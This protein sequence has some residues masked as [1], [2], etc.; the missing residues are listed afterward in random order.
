M[1]I[2]AALESPSV[3]LLIA[4]VFAPAVVG[5]LSLAIP[6][7][8][9]S[10]RTA[11]AVLAPALSLLLLGVSILGGVGSTSVGYEWLPQ[12]HMSLRF[13]PDGL[14]LFFGMLVSMFGVAIALYAR[15]YFGPSREDLYRFYPT[16]LLF[17]TAMLGLV[18]ADSFM[19]ML[20]FWELTS[21]SSFL[22]IGWE[23]DD[24]EA[25]KKALGAFMTTA[26]GGL[27][28][29]AGLI[30]LGVMTGAW[31]FSDL[32][33]LMVFNA[34]QAHPAGVPV[35]LGLMFI[36]IM[37]KSAQWPLH[38]WLPGA[39]SAPTPVSAY[40]HSATMV[41][42][43]IYLLARLAPLFAWSVAW[44]VLVIPIG[45]ITML[46][47]AY[48]ALRKDV[49]KHI[50][51]Y[52]TISQLGLLAVMYG[53]AHWRHEHVVLG[54][55]LGGGAGGGQE[56]MQ[57]NLIWDTVQ[58]LNHALYKAPLF[59]LAGAV[60]H[61]LHVKQ[62]SQVQGLVWKGGSRTIIALLLAAAAY[63][64]AAGPFTLSFAA[65]EMFLY[66]I[67]HA[68]HD[69]GPWYLW[70]LQ[71]AAVATSVLN[72]AIFV[73]IVAVLFSRTRRQR[74]YRQDPD[75][76][77]DTEEL[78][79]HAEPSVLWN[80]MLWLPAAAILV[81]Q[82]VG[83]IFPGVIG[84]ALGPLATNRNYF[85]SIPTSLALLGHPGKPL[86]MSAA[87]VVLGVLLGLSPLLRR[88]V[89]DWHDAIF[90]A[91]YKL[92]TVGGGRVFGLVQTGFFRTYMAVSC[93]SLVAVVA[94]TSEGAVFNNWP[95]LGMGL[96][97][98]PDRIHPL[99]PCLLL[100]AIICV[101]AVMMT[102]TRDRASRILLLGTVGFCVT[103]MFY[104]YNAPDLALTQ[105]SIE[106]VSLI[107]F[108]L[109]LS[110]LPAT[111]E[112]K[113]RRRVLRLGVALATGATM[114]LVTFMSVG[115]AR[116]GLALADAQGRQFTRLG[117][118]FLRN[119]YAGVDDVDPA[120]K[121]AAAS[122]GADDSSAEHDDTPQGETPQGEAAIDA[123]GPDAAGLHAAGHAAAGRGGGGRNVVNVI[124]VDFR[125]YDTL[126]EITVLG[127]AAL[128]V[129]TLLRRFHPP[130]MQSKQPRTGGTEA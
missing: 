22:L 34:Q 77:S 21:V 60:T 32:S 53:L 23:R 18:L 61:M 67:V 16:L 45:A 46:L 20:L 127:L 69:G 54:G 116:P 27:S 48:V 47:G 102:L 40:L 70:F 104:L 79:L 111:V 52:T 73:R 123:A 72:V 59:I 71:A 55:V 119:S 3:N 38:F 15:A 96:G 81:P 25:V 130:G 122:P 10:L 95:K 24:E 82:F 63:A 84:Q 80:A 58:V 26:L 105:I 14:G 44:P 12:F 6:R 2:L 126:G 100:T 31:R 43:G 17:M 128:G 33:L 49:L 106:I 28:L 30:W 68:M 39:M 110:Q 75:L 97:V 74:A 11:L 57:P 94:W 35:A 9:T 66:Q 19:L 29:M 91:F 118:Y 13:V 51:A 1:P 87:A 36:G 99:L 56:V 101:A 115:Q 78:E 65:K 4:A 129:W 64:L 121:P 8:M 5:L 37:A 117:D 86:Y 124:L 120:A 83:G 92:C 114:A 90:P 76:Y 85:D 42:A 7:G 62:L 50:F 108:L 112:Q 125:G 89:S 93:L 103:G 88:V 107:L 41:K 98:M 113:K 109:V